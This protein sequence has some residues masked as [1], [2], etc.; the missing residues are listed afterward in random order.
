[1]PD[2]PKGRTNSAPE[3]TGN[4]DDSAIPASRNKR[5]LII[6]A[7]ALLVIFG[8]IGAYVFFGGHDEPGTVTIEIGG[9]TVYHEL[10]EILT[11]LTGEETSSNHVKL[12]IIIEVLESHVGVL[13]NK[14]PAIVD[15]IQAYL[16]GKTREELAGE[17][18]AER[19]RGELLIMI[20]QR[21]A[22]GEANDILFKT[23]LID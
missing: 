7:A 4:Q 9:E 3:E 6:A 11:H 23:F 1:M 18:G 12:E 5:W 2:D 15:A 19:L 17:A 14:E 10:P 13:Q 16:R 8:A 22:P 21:I 20:N